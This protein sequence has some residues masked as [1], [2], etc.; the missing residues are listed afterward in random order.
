[1]KKNITIIFA[2][3]LLIPS[4]LLIAPFNNAFAVQPDEILSDPKQEKRAREIS[5]GLRCLVCQNQSIDDSNADLAK[6]LRLIVRERI[7][8][9]DNNQQV[10]QYIIDRY[11]NYVL[12][13]PPVNFQTIIL[14]LGP[15]IILLF[16]IFAVV[17][18]YRGI[19]KDND[20][21]NP[22]NNKN[23]AKLSTSEQARLEAILKE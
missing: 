10:M 15:L 12:L 6:D 18:W 5:K 14:W 17:V 23:I 22:K 1:M 13:E 11:G 2:V 16:G 7:V 4:F 20:K 19:K 3:F 21:Q 9:G 8:I